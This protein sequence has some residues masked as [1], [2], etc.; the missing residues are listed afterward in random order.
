[1]RCRL[2]VVMNQRFLSVELTADELE[3]PYVVIDRGNAEWTASCKVLGAYRERRSHKGVLRPV[4]DS[5]VDSHGDGLRRLRAETLAATAGPAPR[6]RRS[7]AAA[8]EMRWSA[9][10]GPRAQQ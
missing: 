2:Q 5:R 7:R 6:A 10:P 4:V 1:M 9:D 3:T 8:A